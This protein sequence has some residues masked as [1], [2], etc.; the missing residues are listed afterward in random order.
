MNGALFLFSEKK[1]AG[2]EGG[3][4]RP[5]NFNHSVSRPP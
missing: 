3:K 1:K 4:R 5:N 2:V